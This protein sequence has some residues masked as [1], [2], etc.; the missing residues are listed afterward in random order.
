M[1]RKDYPEDDNQDHAQSH[2]IGDPVED[3]NDSAA[4][5]VQSEIGNSDNDDDDDDNDDNEVGDLGDQSCDRSSAILKSFCKA[6]RRVKKVM[7]AH[8]R[9][10][11]E[12]RLFLESQLKE[13]PSVSNS[14]AVTV[15][16]CFKKRRQ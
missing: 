5:V 15:C 13:C 8:R 7:D 10:T 12:L 2:G 14:L 16:T 4:V 9:E 3:L 1:N 11:R 6:V